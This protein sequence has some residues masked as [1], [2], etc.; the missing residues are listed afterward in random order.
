MFNKFFKSLLPFLI[1]FTSQLPAV[2]FLD[3]GDET[4]KDETTKLIWQK[5]SAGL[6]G[7]SC[8]SGSATTFTWVNAISYCNTLSLGSKTWRLPNLNELR[9]I[10]DYTKA[11][12]PMIDTTAFPAT[13]A[14]AY[15]SSTTYATTTTNAWAVYFPFGFSGNAYPKT[16]TNYV[17]CISGP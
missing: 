3:N 11:S 5:C 4:V 14:N 15:W 17:R 12:S 7:S 16:V 1:L 13:V 10:I 6:T 9:T 2:P 8:S